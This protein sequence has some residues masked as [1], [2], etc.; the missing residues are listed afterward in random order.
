MLNEKQ[1]WAKI[2]TITSISKS[3]VY[4][5]TAV[6]RESSWEQDTDMIIEVKHVIDVPRSSR[7]QIT[8]AA[9]KCILKF[10]LQNSTTRGF[11]CDTLAKEARKRGHEIAPRTV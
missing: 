7:L 6:V 10:I 11:S 1:P 4:A 5:L 2:T 9:I 8:T 3:R